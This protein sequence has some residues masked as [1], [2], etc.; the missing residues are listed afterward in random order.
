MENVTFYSFSFSLNKQSNDRL[1][2]AFKQVVQCHEED[3]GYPL[4]VYGNLRVPKLGVPSLRRWIT[5]LIVGFGG[6]Q[7]SNHLSQWLIPDHG[8][9]TADLYQRIESL[10]RFISLL[11]GC[12]SFVFQSSDEKI[13]RLECWDL[14]IENKLTDLENDI[15]ALR[16]AKSSPSRAEKIKNS[17]FD[18][19]LLLEFTQS[20]SQLKRFKI[21]S[22]AADLL[23]SHVKKPKVA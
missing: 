13:R 9:A 16:K 21:C 12:R 10:Q 5:N 6:V 3:Y 19:S 11:D 22:E 20:F 14:A 4:N 1:V 2:E 7:V 23:G 17:I 18:I 15:E 8:E